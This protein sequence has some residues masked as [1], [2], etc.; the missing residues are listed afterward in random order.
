MNKERQCLLNNRED[1]IFECWQ[2]SLYSTEG[3]WLDKGR[4]GKIHGREDGAKVTD[5][6]HEEKL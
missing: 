4:D 2:V 6:L 3:T 1:G 5:T